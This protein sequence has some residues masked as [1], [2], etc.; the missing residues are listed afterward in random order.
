MEAP[1]TTSPTAS[2]ALKVSPSLARMSETDQP[3]A[4]LF[5]QGLNQRLFW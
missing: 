5:I 2:T 4:H 1:S 3:M